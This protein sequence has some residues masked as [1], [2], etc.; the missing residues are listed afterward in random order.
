MRV[1]RREAASKADELATSW[2]ANAA[3]WTQAVR[4]GR[5]E[6][7]RLVTDAAVVEAVLRLRPERVLDVGC[8]EGWLCRRLTDEGVATT[9]I[10][11]STPLVRAARTAHRGDYRVLSYDELVADPRYAGGPFDVVVCNFALLGADLAPV[12]AALRATLA[13]DGHLVV[14]TIHPWTQPPPYADGWREETFDGFGEDGWTA[15]PWYFRTL[16]SW[17]AALTKAGFDRV[18]ID[19]PLHPETQQPASLVLLASMIA[20]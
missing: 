16:G 1:D 10:D 9:G 3:A 11:A 2:V 8:G 7:R 17:M 6:S 13:E 20:A 18:E 5:I 15:M 4:E 19:E 14:Q 12:L